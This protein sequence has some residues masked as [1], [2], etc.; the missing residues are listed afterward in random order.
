MAELPAEL[1]DGDALRVA[2]QDGLIEFGCRLHSLHNNKNTIELSDDWEWESVTRN[3]SGSSAQRFGSKSMAEILALF[4]ADDAHLATCHGFHTDVCCH[5]RVVQPVRVALAEWRAS[6]VTERPHGRLRAEA[7]GLPRQ[8]LSEKGERPTDSAFIA[9]RLRD[10]Q[11]LNSQAAIAKVMTEQL[12]RKVH[13]GEVSR[14][15]LRVD[16][17]RKAGGIFPDLPSL[18]EKP[19]PVDPTIVEMGKRQDGLTPRQRPRRDPDAD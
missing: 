2:D 14:W 12:G 13:Q 8:E 3:L 4:E 10:F 5:V 7:G 17:Y 15:L 9:W 1:R 19:R 11:G 16:E 18:T 6:R